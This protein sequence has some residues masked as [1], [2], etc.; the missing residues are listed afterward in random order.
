MYKKL[1]GF[2]S[3]RYASV[4][5]FI[6]GFCE[7]VFFFI[8]PDVFFTF[9]AIFSPVRGLLHCLI[10][11]LG[12][13]FGGV[14]MYELSRYDPQAMTDFVLN[15]P[16]ISSSMVGL[17]HENFQSHGLIALFMGPWQGIPY[18]VYALQAGIMNVG[19]ISFILATVPAR[20]ERILLLAMIS[21]GIG[22]VFKGKIQKRPALWA[23]AVVILWLVVYALYVV[24]LN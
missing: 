10:S 13:V 9:T 5:A 21:A 18:K 23:G 24:K 12:S 4:I 11:V 1:F 3:S 6:W 16:L 8:V 15:V 19:L 22:H 7:A 14:V 17:V 2:A 20:L